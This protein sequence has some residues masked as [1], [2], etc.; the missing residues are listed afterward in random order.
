VNEVPVAETQF[1]FRGVDSN[2]L[3]EHSTCVIEKVRIRFAVDKYLVDLDLAYYVDEAVKDL[4]QLLSVSWQ[5][6]SIVIDHQPL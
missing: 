5:L 6:G 2:L 4:I 1:S 3:I